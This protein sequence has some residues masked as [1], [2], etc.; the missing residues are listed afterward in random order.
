MELRCLQLNFID[1]AQL[2]RLTYQTPVAQGGPDSPPCD[3]KSEWTAVRPWVPDGTEIIPLCSK[4]NISLLLHFWGIK[5][6]KCICKKNKQSKTFSLIQCFST[7]YLSYVFK[8][9]LK[10]PSPLTLFGLSSVMIL[11]LRILNLL[12]Q[13][14]LL[15]APLTTKPSALTC[16]LTTALGTH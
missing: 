12:V 4:G 13:T 11:K 3:L 9:K 16:R 7:T 6:K 15:L 5:R 14:P 2:P 8:K 10:K 1:K